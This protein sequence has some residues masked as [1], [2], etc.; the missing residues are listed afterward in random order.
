[1]KLA[2]VGL[3]LGTKRP[4]RDADHSPSSTA[5]TENSGAIPPPKR[6]INI[7]RLGLDSCL[8]I[9]SQS[10]VLSRV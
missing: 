6:W 4:Y 2:Q 3:S 1:M 8:R 5:E 10:V 7:S 9:L